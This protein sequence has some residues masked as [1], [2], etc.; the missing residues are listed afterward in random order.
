ME[1]TPRILVRRLVG[2]LALAMMLPVLAGCK[3][4]ETQPDFQAGFEARNQILLQKVAQ[5]YKPAQWHDRGKYSFPKAIARIEVYGNE[6]AEALGYLREYANGRYDF[7]HFPFVGLIRLLGLY[8][9]NSVIREQRQ[10]MLERI[11]NHDP[12]YHYNALTGEGTENHVAMSRTSGYLFAEEAMQYPDLAEKAAE[13]Q[14]LLKPWILQWARHCYAVGTG[15]WDSG[16]YTAYNLIGWLNLYDF[17]RDPEVKA[18]ARAVVDYYAANMALKYTDGFHGGAESRGST[19]YDQAPRTA[20]EYFDWLWFGEADQSTGKEFFKGAEYIQAV[21]A[22]SSSYRP[23]AAVVALARKQR[24]SVV[25]P[26]EYRLSKP[27]Y[28]MLEAGRIGEETFCID[29]SY[30]AGTAQTRVGGWSNASYGL[31]NWKVVLRN[32]SGQPAVLWGNGGMKSTQHARGRNPWD[33]FGQSGRVIIQM[34]RVPEDAQAEAEQMAA[35]V[36]HWREAHDADF[37]KRWGRQHMEYPEHVMDTARGKVEDASQSFVLS[38]GA[39]VPFRLVVGRTDAAWMAHGSNVV[40]ART[41]SGNAIVF[42]D[43]GAIFDR[44]EPGDVCGFIL[45]IVPLNEEGLPLDNAALQ[46]IAGTGL[47]YDAD[48]RR[49]TYTDTTGRRIGFAYSETGDWEEM[50]FDWGWGV[51]DQQVSFNNPALQ[52]PDWPVGAGQGRLLQLWVNGQSQQR[53]PDGVVIDGPD[54][55]LSG[56]VLEVL[57]EG[58]AAY[59]VDF[60]GQLPRFE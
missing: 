23:P 31:I 51:Q 28:L 7:F 15:E 8:P 1:M 10:E 18:A 29:H 32:P 37:Q 46:A 48:S 60:S 9:E 41:L 16:V 26:A 59:R 12:Q 38:P 22:A 27:D 45:E 4:L 50:M 53:L 39:A 36:E 47:A 20:T 3:T 57:T 54:L 55:R 25:M 13:W 52:H 40:I 24:G 5:D 2:V 21:H 49:W 19:R 43:N 6:D 35:L 33:Q 30:T 14:R 58:R 56:G 17:A 44:T 11:L 34:T 42:A